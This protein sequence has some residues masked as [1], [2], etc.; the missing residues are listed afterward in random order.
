[1]VEL[2]DIGGPAMLRAAAKNHSGVLALI[3]PADYEQAAECLKS[4]AV[5]QEFQT[6]MASK[7]GSTAPG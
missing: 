4:G 1:M 3:D 7:T 5:P 2:I 6:R